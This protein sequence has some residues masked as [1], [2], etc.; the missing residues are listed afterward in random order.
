MMIDLTS[1]PAEVREVDDLTRLH[2]LAPTG[3]DVDRALRASGLGSQDPDGR[4][5]LDVTAL[6]GA[7]VALA[8][9]PAWPSGWDA[10]VAYAVSKDWLADDGAALVAHVERTR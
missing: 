2:V 6:R 9:D 7:A 1:G 10:M 4:V 8:S 5:L 3:L